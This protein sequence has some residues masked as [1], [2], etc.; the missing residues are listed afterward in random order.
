[1]H[2][3]LHML[4]AATPVN[5]Q[6]DIGVD[7]TNTIYGYHET[8][9]EGGS[10]PTGGCTPVTIRGYTIYICGQWDVTGVNENFDFSI[11]NTGSELGASWFTSL[12][13]EHS[14]GTNTLNTADAVHSFGGG[15]ETWK[16]DSATYFP[17]NWIGEQGNVRN[18]RMVP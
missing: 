11:R 18:V 9:N 8:A 10:P 16:W 15:F 1:M 14:S 6:V 5:W 12:V 4:A 7:D 2:P 3:L 13:V 17:G